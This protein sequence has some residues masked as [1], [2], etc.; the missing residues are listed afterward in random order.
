MSDDI[1][2]SLLVVHPSV[3][4]D[5]MG[6]EGILWNTHGISNTTGT[7]VRLTTMMSIGVRENDLDATRRDACARTGTFTPVVIPAT[8]HFNGKLI[9]V[10]VIVIGW[11]T[12][13]EWTVAFFVIRITVFIPILAQPL[14]ATVFHSPH[15]ML[16]RL[17]DIQHLAT[18]FCL[19]DVKHLTT[20][21]GTTAI[22]VVLVANC[23]QFEHVLS[24]DAFIATLIKKDTGI[25]AVIDDG[26]AHQFH[27]LFPTGTSNI[28]LSI[29]SR[30]SLYQ[31]YTVA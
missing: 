20:A 27:A 16:V 15:R 2:L 22:G 12:T 14:V 5:L 26:I 7:I 1:G 30:H 6:I 10:V 18:I 25:V 21:N 19:I 9:H 31:S 29:T 8:Y 17:V 3:P 13:T 23:L 24:R 11:L 28:L 4:H